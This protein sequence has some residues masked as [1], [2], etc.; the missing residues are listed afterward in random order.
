MS[1]WD[2]SVEDIRNDV[3][4]SGMSRTAMMREIKETLR[5]IRLSLPNYRAI[6]EPRRYQ[7]TLD[8]V[9]D[10]ELMYNQ[11]LNDTANVFEDEDFQETLILVRV[12]YQ[13]IMGILDRFNRGE[14][15]TPRD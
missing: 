15:Q 5:G 8:D 10:A 7:I 6:Q 4:T 9:E 11:F 3:E 1:D 14:W 12:K 2:R 13:T